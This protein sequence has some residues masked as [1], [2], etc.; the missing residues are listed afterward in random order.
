MTL[1]C[2][3]DLNGDVVLCVSC[4]FGVCHAL[5]VFSWCSGTWVCGASPLRL[6]RSPR[7]AQGGARPQPCRRT[8]PAPPTPTAAPTGWRA[9]CATTA[10]TGRAGEVAP[11]GSVRVAAPSRVWSAPAS[12]HAS[13]PAA[14]T[15]AVLSA[16]CRA[17]LLTDATRIR[18]CDHNH[19]H[20]HSGAHTT[21]RVMRRWSTQWAH[22]PHAP[23]FRPY[24]HTTVRS[25]SLTRTRPPLAATRPMLPCPTCASIAAHTHMHMP[26]PITSP[27]ASRHRRPPRP[28]PCPCP[29]RGTHDQ[30]CHATVEP[31]GGAWGH[32]PE[33][34]PCHH[35]TVRSRSLTRT[36][37]PPAAARPG[38][39]LSHVRLHHR[40]HT[41]THATA[42]H[43][44]PRIATSP[45][46]VTPA[47]PMSTA[48][49]TRPSVSRDG[50]ALRGSVGTMCPRVVRATTP[51]CH[52][53]LRHTPVRLALQHAPGSPFPHAPRPPPTHTY[54]RHDRPQAPT[55][56]D[57]AVRVAP[58]CSHTPCL[59][60]PRTALRNLA[61]VGTA[62]ASLKHTRRRVPTHKCLPLH[63]THH[64]RCAPWRPGQGPPPIKSRRENPQPPTA[65]RH[66]CGSLSPAPSTSVATVQCNDVRRAVTTTLTPGPPQ[67]VRPRPPHSRARTAL[68]AP[69][70]GR[71]PPT[72]TSTDTPP[73]RHVSPTR[74]RV[75]LSRHGSLL[76][77]PSHILLSPLPPNGTVAPAPP[78]P[79]HAHIPHHTT[80]PPP[81]HRHPA[82]RTSSHPPPR[83]GSRP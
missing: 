81:P 79:P 82:S 3:A 11:L 72:L 64:R 33:C 60:M 53:A 83:Q 5:F 48:G 45:F 37:P 24:H 4:Q 16:P 74:C 73:T 51:P 50:G 58:A 28:Q 42:D 49:H 59:P 19:A 62:T 27:H 32:V 7:S 78:S 29:Q 54:T 14:N 56:R 38:L 40:P 10:V 77:P 8:P 80:T 63:L 41:H 6:D 1:T 75:R 70:V 55:H 76:L 9:A 22:G 13:P 57:V 43:K 35:T 68:G 23:E 47:M 66:G 25:R 17:S 71:C 21:K 31:S 30:A 46:A 12:P 36:R 61:A 34:R 44:P 20:V 2:T 15:H 65:P 26:R 18:H 67:A 69:S 52:L 39:P